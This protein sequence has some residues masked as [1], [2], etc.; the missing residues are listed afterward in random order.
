MDSKEKDKVEN[1]TDMQKNAVEPS[2]YDGQNPATAGPGGTAVQ[3]QTPENANGKINPSA[4]NDV[5]TTPERVV[6]QTPDRK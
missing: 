6:N 4:P 3:S 2:G 1:R 5:N